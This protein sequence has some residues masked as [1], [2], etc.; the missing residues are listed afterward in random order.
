MDLHLNVGLML[1]VTGGL[2]LLL[3]IALDAASRRRR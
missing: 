2:T 3:G 1:V